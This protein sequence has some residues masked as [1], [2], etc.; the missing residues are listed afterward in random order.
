MSKPNKDTIII[1]DFIPN[2]NDAPWLNVEA[3]DYRYLKN[4][5]SSH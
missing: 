5:P 4:K 3:I 1:P 2:F